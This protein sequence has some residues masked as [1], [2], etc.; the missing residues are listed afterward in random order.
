MK[1]EQMQNSVQGCIL[2]VSHKFLQRNFEKAA[3]LEVHPGQIPIIR[4]LSEHEGASQ[5]ELAD[6]L[7]IKPPTVNV[8]IQRME[9]SGFVYREPD[10]KDQRVTRIYLTEKGKTIDKELGQLMEENEKIITSGFSESELCL[11]KRMLHQM[12]ENLE[13]KS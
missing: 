13:N 7:R 11:L 5:R 4:F 12:M 6:L 10:E 1:R 8:S 2:D 3:K 9:K